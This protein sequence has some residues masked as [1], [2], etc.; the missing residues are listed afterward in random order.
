MQCREPAHRDADDMR[1][2]DAE[3]VEHVADVVARPLL[4]VSPPILRHVGRRIAARVERDNAVAPREKP[5]LRLVAAV[6][7]GEF[8]HEHDRVAG[9]GLFVIEPDAVVG[10]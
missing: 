8:V 9:P 3:P 5:Q 10:G 6:I 2:C 4:R 1:L 7:A